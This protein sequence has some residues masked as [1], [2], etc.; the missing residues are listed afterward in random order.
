M[1][2]IVVSS[3]LQRSPKSM[4]AHQKMFGVVAEAQRHTA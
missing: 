1:R 3:V 4:C 2:R